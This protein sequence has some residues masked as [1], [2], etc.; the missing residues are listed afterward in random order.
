M[1]A[2]NI[3]AYQL[4]YTSGIVDFFPVNFPAFDLPEQN[5]FCET[6]WLGFQD[7][8]RKRPHTQGAAE[9]NLFNQVTFRALQ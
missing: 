2:G 4:W 3:R 5:P 1:I 6:G 7:E 9:Y 8:W